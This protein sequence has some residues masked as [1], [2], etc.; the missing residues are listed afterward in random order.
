M[1]KQESKYCIY[2]NTQGQQCSESAGSEGLCFW[3]DP[4]Q[5]KTGE[6]VKQKLEE[7]VRNGK[8]L[9]GFALSDANL[10]G[11]NL[12]HPDHQKSTNLS[13][14]DLSHANLSG[15]HLYH[16]NLCGTSLKKTNL[17][18]ANLNRANLDQAQLLGINLEDVK[19][20]QVNWGTRIIQ[21]V[22]FLILILFLS[23]EYPSYNLRINIKTNVCDLPFTHHLRF[24]YTVWFFRHIVAGLIECARPATFA[25][26]FVFALSAF[27]P[28]QVRLSEFCENG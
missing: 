17:R 27:A 26:L 18:G 25:Y 11:I 23:D 24:V 22:N 12:M 7:R 9:E 19:I 10:E 8:S 5:D 1:S 13:H 28:K 2:I 15:A 16:V 3:H 4:E 20:E 6:G 14:A 21:E